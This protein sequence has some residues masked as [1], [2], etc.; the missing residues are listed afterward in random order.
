MPNWKDIL[1][2]KDSVTYAEDTNPLLRLFRE[3]AYLLCILAAAI[4]HIY[5]CIYP[6]DFWVDE[7]RI[8]V[9]LSQS[10]WLDIFQGNFSSYYQSC[11]IVFAVIN[12]LLSIFTSYTPQILYIIPTVL[13]ICLLFLMHR[14]CLIYEENKAF[15]F[16]CVSCVALCQLPLYY[17]SEFKQYIYEMVVTV[18][19]FSAFFNDLK[20]PSAGKIFTSFKYPLLFIVCLLFSNTSVFIATSICLTMYI[21]TLRSERAG[22]VRVTWAFISRYFIYGA[23]C[24]FYYLFYLRNEDTLLYMYSFWEKFFIPHDISKLPEY[25]DEFFLPMLAGMLKVVLIKKFPLFVLPFFIWGLVC[26]YKKNKY[27]FLSL[28]FLFC[29]VIA[30]AFKFYPLGHASVRGARLSAYLFPVV[31]FI[32]SYGMYKFLYLLYKTTKIRNWVVYMMTLAS[33]AFVIHINGAYIVTHAVYHQ[34]V[35]S[36]FEQMRD[37]YEEGDV[38]CIYHQTEPVFR[39][40]ML[41]NKTR[42]DYIYLKAD[43]GVKNYREDMDIEKTIIDAYD[44]MPENKKMFI[45]YSNFWEI[46]TPPEIYYDIFKA[47][48]YDV[49]EEE[50]KGAALHILSKN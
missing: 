27:E 50:T 33:I 17:S 44:A 47:R 38:L 31:I 16:I 2:R 24:I 23:F 20:K 4:T 10:S 12:K 37:S 6:K 1:L 5:F 14:L 19:L 29:I 40:W 43:L 21:Y 48:G 46:P 22:F 7:A 39:Y 45:I 18:I 9:I 15:A 13:G 35:F 41:I 3:N 11:P 32:A 34:Q 26:I 28:L 36:L 49:K 25:I 42:F 8:A 30:A